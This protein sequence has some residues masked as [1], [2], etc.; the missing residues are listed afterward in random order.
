MLL[1]KHRGFL[2]CGAVLILLGLGIT[3]VAVILPLLISDEI[4]GASAAMHTMIPR[5]KILD[6]AVSTM[7]GLWRRGRVSAGVVPFPV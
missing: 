5:P 7:I 2:G 3:A 4:H 6:R 1:Q